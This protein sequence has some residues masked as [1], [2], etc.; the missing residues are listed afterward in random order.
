MSAKVNWVHL[1]LIFIPGTLWGSSFL[2]NAITLETI[3][4][5]TITAARNLISIPLLLVLLY[6]VGGRLPTSWAGWYPFFV[7]GLVNNAMP[8]FLTSWGQQFIDS[9]LASILLATMPLC[10]IIIAHFVTI[11]ERLTT[12][13]VI[14]VGLGLIGVLVLIGPSALLGLTSGIQGQLALVGAA[15]CYAA[16]GLYAR[17]IFHQKRVPGAS[18]WAVLLEVT[19]GQFIASMIFVA[20][21]SLLLEAPWVLQPSAA[22]LWALLAQA[23]LVSIAAVVVYYYLL[24]AAGATFASMVTYLIPINGVFWGV[25]IRNEALTWQAMAALV[26]ILLGIAVINGLIGQRRRPSPQLSASGNR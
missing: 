8:F 20:P 2:L 21:G 26:L 10:T 9:G 6:L 4:P 11:D 18:P 19:T 24:D 5:M 12:R 3:P 13:K 1:L 14:G 22:S 7:I 23:W 15:T 25:L 17:R 16:G